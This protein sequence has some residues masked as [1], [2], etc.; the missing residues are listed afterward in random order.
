MAYF[1]LKKFFRDQFDSS[2]VYDILRA[3]LFDDGRVG[4]GQL[5]SNLHRYI[6]IILSNLYLNWPSCPAAIEKR[7]LH[8]LPL[9][10]LMLLFL[11]TFQKKNHFIRTAKVSHKS[12]ENN[13]I[14]V[15]KN[16]NDP[17]SAHL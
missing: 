5:A 9:L 14:I 6:I 17:V 15:S 1:F 11:L 2:H 7:Q 10:L 12:N 8:K 4:D 3:I 13:W 16:V